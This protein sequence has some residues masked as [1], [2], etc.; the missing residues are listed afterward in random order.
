MIF[1]RVL[2]P[3]VFHKV[4][5][6]ESI[7]NNNLFANTCRLP[8]FGRTSTTLSNT[9][10]C[11]NYSTVNNGSNYL[12]P[13]TTIV[14]T[15]INRKLATVTGDHVRL[16]VFER[17][18]S[19]GLPITIPAALWTESPILDGLM[20][21]L[22]VMHTHWGLEAIIIDYAR[23]S[24]VG[25]VLPK[26]LHLSLFILSAATLTGLF[27]LINNGPGVSKSIKDF[28][29]IGKKPSEQSSVKENAK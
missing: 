29:A 10:Q 13:K 1:R 22:V 8:Q 28:W 20:S 14:S 27:L 17:L 18:V 7:S 21:L 2:T 4:R 15:Q 19:A 25:P 9:K 11:L 23:P 3:N 12:V 26:I 16:W 24:I 6:L 5:Q